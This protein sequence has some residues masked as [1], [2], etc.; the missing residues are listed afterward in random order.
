MMKRLLGIL[1]DLNIS[2][3]YALR[4]VDLGEGKKS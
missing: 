4:D 1:K 3:S 2:Q